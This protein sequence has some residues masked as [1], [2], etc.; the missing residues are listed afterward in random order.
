MTEDEIT[1]NVLAVIPKG[2]K[3]PWGGA[4]A[5]TYATIRERIDELILARTQPTPS[6]QRK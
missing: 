5:Q 1:T 3:A 4:D 2:K 6:D